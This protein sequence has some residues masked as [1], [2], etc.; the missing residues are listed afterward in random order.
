VARKKALYPDRL[1]L[2]TFSS[3]LATL[4]ARNIFW[5]HEGGN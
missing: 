4:V 3:P 2:S 5:W 1:P